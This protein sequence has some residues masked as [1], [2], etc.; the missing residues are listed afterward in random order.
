[1][2][3]IVPARVAFRGNRRDFPEPDL[4]DRRGRYMVHIP[5]IGKL[6]AIKAAHY[7]ELQQ[8]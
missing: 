5:R 8:Q 2:A 1:M 4:V 6:P 3:N 7:N